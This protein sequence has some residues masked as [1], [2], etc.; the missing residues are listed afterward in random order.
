MAGAGEVLV[1]RT[2]RDLSAGSGLMF[3]D[4]GSHQLKGVPE[5]VQILRYGVRSARG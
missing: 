3:E 2:V 4:R 5:E 1:S